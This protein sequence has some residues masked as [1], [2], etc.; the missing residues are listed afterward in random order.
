MGDLEQQLL[1]LRA[2]TLP[3]GW[4]H[5]LQIKQLQMWGMLAIPECKGLQLS[6]DLDRWVVKYDSIISP[7]SEMP[8]NL[9]DGLARSVR[10]LLGEGWDV[11]VTA[12]NWTYTSE[13][14]VSCRTTKRFRG[15]ESLNTK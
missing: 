6:V 7:E 13:G 1:E 5:E 8:K 3:W 4:L 14:D 11:C 9:L 2:V 10:W 15:D 12:K